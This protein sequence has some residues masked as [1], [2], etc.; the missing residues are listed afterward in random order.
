MWKTRP[1]PSDGHSHHLTRDFVPE[2]TATTNG[3]VHLATAAQYT[4]VACG[5]VHEIYWEDE[6]CL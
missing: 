1:H 3:H 4:T 2:T 5:H 6:E